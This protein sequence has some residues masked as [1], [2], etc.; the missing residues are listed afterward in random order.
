MQAQ[1][2]V[3]DCGGNLG[4]SAIFFRQQ[5][6]SARVTVFEPDPA[7][8]DICAHNLA[9][10]GYQDDV[11]LVRKAVW[12]HDTTLHFDAKGA[13][14]GRVVAGNAATVEVPATALRP[15]LE[16]E[17]VVD[18]VKI[19]IEGAEH[20]VLP[21]IA[22]QLHKVANLFVE[23]HSFEGQSQ[24]LASLLQIITQAGFRYYLETEVKIADAPLRDKLEF[25][26]MD[27][28]VMIFCYRV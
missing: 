22:D 15:Y 6:P 16:R 21:A 11:E 13:A 25:E 27:A 19:D 9:A 7:I 10:F 12:T 17:A 20:A 2:R 8:A 18:M 26:G 28:A 4:L 23:Y 3:L 24:H 1:P 5:Y 14:A